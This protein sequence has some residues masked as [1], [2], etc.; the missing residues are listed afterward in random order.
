MNRT[1][2]VFHA[3]AQHEAEKLLTRRGKYPHLIAH[4]SSQYLR[5]D[6]GGAGTWDRCLEPPIWT[7]RDDLTFRADLT[8]DAGA[9]LLVETGVARAAD[10]VMMRTGPLTRGHLPSMMFSPAGAG[11]RTSIENGVL[12]YTGLT[13]TF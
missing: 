5:P 7:F 2:S 10:D 9:V 13:V 11:V 12:D 6:G 4:V 1:G 3:V 8:D